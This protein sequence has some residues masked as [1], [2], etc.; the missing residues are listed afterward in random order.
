[1]TDT[2]IKDFKAAVIDGYRSA[3]QIDMVSNPDRYNMPF[4]K[5]QIQ[6]NTAFHAAY[7]EIESYSVFDEKYPE[8]TLVSEDGGG[9]GGAEHVSHVYQI[10][11][12]FIEVTGTYTSWDGTNWEYGA[13]GEVFPREVTTI[14]YFTEKP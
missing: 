11:D 8:Y 12:R 13:V 3:V 14:Q 2:L 9:E 6:G 10:G 7:R 4:H 1:M 5:R